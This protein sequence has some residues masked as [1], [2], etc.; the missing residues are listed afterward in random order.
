MAGCDKVLQ[1]LWEYLDKECTE[2]NRQHIKQH[3]DLCRSCYDRMEFEQLL[4]DHMREKTNH[5]C[6]DSVK[7]KIQKLLDLY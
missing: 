1:G 3:L 6:P 2:E 5:C 7:N 4:R